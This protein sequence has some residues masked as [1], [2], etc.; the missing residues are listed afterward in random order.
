MKKIQKC[1]LLRDR[2]TKFDFRLPE[3]NCG[4]IQGCS[5]IDVLNLFGDS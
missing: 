2:E 5:A 1:A 4:E 3:W